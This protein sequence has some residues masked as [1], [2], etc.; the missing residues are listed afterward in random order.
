MSSF[1]PFPRNSVNLVTGPTSSGKTYFVTQLLRHH[2]TYFE[3]TVNRIVVVLCNARI[4]E[5]DLKLSAGDSPEVVQTPLS[6]LDPDQLEENDLVFIDD[7]Q[8]LTEAVRLTISVCAHH[9]NLASL[10]IVTHSLLG[11]KHFELLTLCHRVFLFLKGTA[12]VRLFKYLK[13][14]FFQDPEIQKALEEIVPY[15]QRRNQVL[16]LELN[17]LA[18][19][20]CL[21]DEHNLGP[22]LGISHLS[23]LVNKPEGRGYCVLYT[24]DSTVMDYTE[25]W[26]HVRV[27]P[28]T[29]SNF[30]ASEDPSSMPSA[31]K[32]YALVVVP[33]SAVISS[34]PPLA[35][36][37]E[38]SARD[39]WETTL[40]EI[41][42]SIE[43]HFKSRRWNDCK[44]L[45]KL[46]LRNKDWCVFEDGSH[47]QVRGKPKTQVPLLDFLDEV[48][49]PYI[50]RGAG[51]PPP[52]KPEYQK[53]KPYVQVLKRRG[54][55]SSLLKN[56]YI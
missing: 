55:H 2:E 12:N 32:K 43:S 41:E 39:Q 53:Y 34:R 54:A 8:A 50:N 20:C 30:S 13:S 6:D 36:G 33:T 14:H 45:A 49:K 40:R 31:L 4:Q 46:I 56:P 44:N 25:E 26:Q 7:L 21:P 9:Y 42:D 29:A 52:N 15:C 11:N 27:D 38:C 24:L 51:N 23:S 5:L 22:V 16:G 3:G 10:F 47:F 28:D 1:Q 48:T 17:P 35:E 19:S 18:S 37:G